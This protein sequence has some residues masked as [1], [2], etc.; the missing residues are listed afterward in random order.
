MNSFQG[1]AEENIV[2]SI[3]FPFALYLFLQGKYIGKFMMDHSHLFNVK[4]LHAFCFLS[5]D[6]TSYTLC[7]RSLLVE[8]LSF[9]SGQSL[10]ILS[11][12]YVPSLVSFS[13]GVCSSMLFIR[14]AQGEE[15]CVQKVAFYFSRI[16]TDVFSHVFWFGFTLGRKSERST[17]YLEDDCGY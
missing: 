13:S 5:I 11:L 14:W 15:T 16:L 9:S 12:L 2:V 8:I 6:P 7:Y 4:Y 3:N 1:P 10:D 17:W